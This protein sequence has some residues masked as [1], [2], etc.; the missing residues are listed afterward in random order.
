[1]AGECCALYAQQAGFISPVTFSL[2]ANVLVLVMLCV[3]GSG[4]MLGPAVGAAI[5]TLVPYVL[6]TT[7]Q[8]TY[9]VQGLILFAV[10]RFLPDGV[11][12]TIAKRFSRLA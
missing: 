5:M 6:I 1:V 11:V 9:L 8:Y 12:G 3:G 7:Q 2:F 4:T 10:L